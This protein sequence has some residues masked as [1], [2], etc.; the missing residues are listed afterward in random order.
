MILRASYATLGLMGLSKSKLKMETA[1]LL[2][3]GK[4]VYDCH[5]CTHARNS[6]SK[7]KF[8]SRVTWGEISFDDLKLLP[9]SVKRVCIQVVSYP[10]YKNDLKELL[11][12]LRS[13][14]V[15]LSVRTTTLQEIKE[16]FNLGVDSIGISVDVVSPE[17]FKIIRGGDLKKVINLLEEAAQLYPEKITTH[18]IVGLGETDKQLIDFFYFMKKLNINVALFAFTPIK[19][20][21]LENLTPPTMERYRKIQLARYLIYHTKTKENTF[22]FDKEG[23]LH[24]IHV[25]PSKELSK[26]F[27]TSGCRHCTRPYYNERPGTNL[28]NYHIYNEHLVEE[29]KKVLSG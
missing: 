13:Y 29:L 8:L 23:N 3:D 21:K 9:E 18:V 15:S 4:C 6:N 12:F 14:T 22:E 7:N 1:Y 5:F 16:Y 24:K 10:G 25:K 26:A 2:L 27:M 17:L 19:G 28:Y 11:N 20:T